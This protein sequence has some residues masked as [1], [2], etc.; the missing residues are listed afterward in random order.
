MNIVARYRE[1]DT[2]ERMCLDVIVSIRHNQYSL[3]LKLR[4]SVLYHFS[5]CH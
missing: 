3:K 2:N 4:E 5:Q 1:R